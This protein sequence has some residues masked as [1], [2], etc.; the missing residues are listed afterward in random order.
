MDAN[1]F[2]PRNRGATV[3]RETVEVDLTSAPILYFKSPPETSSA[4]E[5]AWLKAMLR[6]DVG[7]FLPTSYFGLRLR[8]VLVDRC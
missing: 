1:S 3:F 8:A 4:T 5:V 2:I 6:D 7:A